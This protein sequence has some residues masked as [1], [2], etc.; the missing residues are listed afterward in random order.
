MKITP[1]QR[2]ELGIKRARQ[3]YRILEVLADKGYSPSEVAREINCSPAN[4]SKVLNGKGHSPAVLKKLREVGVPEKYL[5]DPQ[6]Q[7]AV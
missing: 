4:V 7:E 3:R 6:K 2:S 1:R 5:F